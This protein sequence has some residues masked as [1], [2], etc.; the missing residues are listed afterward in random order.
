VSTHI[1]RN[2]SGGIAVLFGRRPTPAAH[3]TWSPKGPYTN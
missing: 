2:R 3:R 1:R